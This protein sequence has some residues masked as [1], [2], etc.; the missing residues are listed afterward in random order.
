MSFYCYIFVLVISIIMQYCRYLNL[1]PGPVFIISTFTSLGC[2][3]PGVSDNEDQHRP[4]SHVGRAIQS[5][6]LFHGDLIYKSRIRISQCC[7]LISMLQRIVTMS[8]MEAEYVA[9]LFAAQM[10]V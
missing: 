5:G 4:V 1:D 2:H 7:A 6:L 3:V 9:C 8:S 10:V